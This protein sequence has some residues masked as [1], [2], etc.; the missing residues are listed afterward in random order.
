M[1][2]RSSSPSGLLGGG[3][4]NTGINGIVLLV[5]RTTAGE[6]DRGGTSLGGADGGS[7]IMVFCACSRERVSRCACSRSACSMAR[8]EPKRAVRCLAIICSTTCSSSAE[9]CAARSGR[10]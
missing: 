6:A 5:S 10:R 8:I 7:E 4:E 1:V 2:L 9:I 3:C